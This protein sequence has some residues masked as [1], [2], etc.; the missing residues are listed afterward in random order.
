MDKEDATNVPGL[1][2]IGDVAEGR[3]ELTPVAIQSGRLLAE[4]LYGE[5]GEVRAAEGSAGGDPPRV[6]TSFGRSPQQTI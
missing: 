5:P 6:Q 3:P 2:A 4:R 1:Y